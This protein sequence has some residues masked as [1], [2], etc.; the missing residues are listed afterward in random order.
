[1][2]SICE[3]ERKPGKGRNAPER[4]KEKPE[5]SEEVPAVGL[6]LENQICGIGTL[7]RKDIPCRP[8]AINKL[9]VDIIKQACRCAAAGKRRSACRG[10]DDDLSI[11]SRVVAD[12]A[13]ARAGIGGD[14]ACGAI[15]DGVS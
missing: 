7:P 2:K 5:W 12:T 6:R 9:I 1:M 10:G 3:R 11:P 14:T 4:K 13:V 8:I 15:R